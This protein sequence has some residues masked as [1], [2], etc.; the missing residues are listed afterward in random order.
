M[1]L[2]QVAKRVQSM[3]ETGSKFSQINRHIMY[4][5]FAVTFAKHA[6]IFHAVSE[7]NSRLLYW[8]G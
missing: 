1:K 8:S 5:V 7:V 2:L 6:T 4:E 3:G